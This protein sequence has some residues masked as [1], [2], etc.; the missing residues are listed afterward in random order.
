MSAN[1]VSIA[2][3]SVMVLCSV[4]MKER[5]LQELFSCICST[6]LTR[7]TDSWHQ[8]FYFSYHFLV[9]SRLYR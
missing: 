2:K 1:S 4:P 7:W 3:V 5:S 6:Q 9:S 8:N